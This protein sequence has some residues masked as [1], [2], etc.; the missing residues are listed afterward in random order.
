MQTTPNRSQILTLAWNLHKAG[1]SFSDAQRK[2]WKVYNL[3][4]R[5]KAGAVEFT[6]QKK[7]GSTRQATGTTSSTFF[8]YT[9]KTDRITPSHLV[10]Y[11]DLDKNSFR[12]F[13]A[14]NILEVA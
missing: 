14:A 12:S 13:K 3:K 4:N 8:S 7:D 11:F 1:L 2:A 6:Y 5:M 9:R 10:T